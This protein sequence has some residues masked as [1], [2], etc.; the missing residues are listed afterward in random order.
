MRSRPIEIGWVDSLLRAGL[1]TAR[2]D[3]L[4]VN[5]S[6]GGDAE[7]GRC[8]DHLRRCMSVETN[9]VRAGDNV[10]ESLTSS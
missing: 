3:E 8:A 7:A 5:G 6:C 10:G 4:F 1:V 2:Q 9:R